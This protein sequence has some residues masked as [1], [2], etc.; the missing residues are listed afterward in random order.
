MAKLEDLGMEGKVAVAQVSKERANS[1][2]SD[3]VEVAML[4][5]H[6]N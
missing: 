3:G 4:S 1:K 6:E 5:K 2:S